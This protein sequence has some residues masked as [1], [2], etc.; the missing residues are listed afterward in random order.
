MLIFCSM[1]T[2]ELCLCQINVGWWM[3]PTSS[4]P[5]V[6]LYSGREG[7]GSETAL[8]A[9]C[10]HPRGSLLPF[11][12]LSPK[13]DR[14]ASS[15]HVKWWATALFLCL[16]QV[17]DYELSVCI[18]GTKSCLPNPEPEIKWHLEQFHP[19]GFLDT[20]CNDERR[21]DWKCLQEEQHI[22]KKNSD[23]KQCKS[24]D[25]KAEKTDMRLHFN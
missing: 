21:S 16:M 5:F 3:K 25:S 7:P 8:Q 13:E 9:R 4:Q 19:D 12:S 18:H 2:A 23:I 1:R 15:L 10:M 20:E 24:Q 22:N 6:R 17:P 14:G 11:H